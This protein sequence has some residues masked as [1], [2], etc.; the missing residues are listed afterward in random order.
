MFELSV[1]LKYLIPRKKQLSVSLIAVM[2][3]VVISL[4]VWLVLIFLSVTEGMEKNWLDK[5]TS[6]N[7]PVR[8]TPTDQYYSSY[9]YLID[10]HSAASHFTSKNISQ[11]RST[12]I[13]DPYALDEDA[14]LPFQFPSPE[15]NPNRKIKDPVKEA[16]RILAEL[17]EKQPDL[18]YQDFEISGA[19]M[20]L[21][22][23]RSNPSSQENSQS[24]LTQV[25][26]LASIPDRS[27]HFAKMVLSPTE[28]D[29][30]HLF[31]LSSHA[32]ESA[33][34]DSPSLTLLASTERANKRFKEL[35]G[36][37][38]IQKLQSTS[39]WELSFSLL[40]ENIPFQCTPSR[41][42][43]KFLNIIISNE[44]KIRMALEKKEDSYGAQKRIY[45]FK[46]KEQKNLRCLLQFL[47]L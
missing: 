10:K 42:G 21:Q 22:L 3:V 9:Y 4:V 26:Y 1:A 32:T 13:S 34:E 14:E 33:K 24:F 5:L 39:P 11:K 16:Y 46:M 18:S 29:L 17:Q 31:Y 20:R 40:P 7:A 47:F 36:S 30:N 8:I 25:S 28:K 37:A 35:L 15:L 2:S 41:Y 12:C 23:L 19:L 43:D 44:K 38:Q 45:F 6:L 27:P